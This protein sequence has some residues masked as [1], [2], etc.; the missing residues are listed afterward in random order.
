[1][2]GELEELEKALP[3]AVDLLPEGGKLAIITFHSLEDR[4]VKNFFRQCAKED[5]AE[6]LTK[7]PIYPT[8]DEIAQNPRA[9]SAKLRA[10]TRIANQES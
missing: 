5:K 3:Q 2:N 6:I 8:D 7:K 10:I 4:I 9:R 1:M